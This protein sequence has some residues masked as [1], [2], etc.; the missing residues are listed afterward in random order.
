MCPTRRRAREH[1]LLGGRLRWLRGVRVALV[2][3][4]GGPHT[5]RRRPG[6]R[7]AVQRGRGTKRSCKFEATPPADH[8]RQLRPLAAS[9]EAGVQRIRFRRFAARSKTAVSVCSWARPDGP[10]HERVRTVLYAVSLSRRPLTWRWMSAAIRSLG[11]SGVA[12]LGLGQKTACGVT[13]HR[14]MPT[15]IIMVSA[16]RSLQARSSVSHQGGFSG[17]RSR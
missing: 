16:C 13:F 15:P 4:C 17:P 1:H 8:A 7:R 12:A 2:R 3:R 9:R 14:T 6:S 11:P 10:V 5:P